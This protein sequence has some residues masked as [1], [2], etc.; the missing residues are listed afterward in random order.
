MS[1]DDEA[2]RSHRI[3]F[4]S[5]IDEM[6]DVNMLLAGRTN[7]YRRQRRNSQ[8]FVGA[9]FAMAV[10]AVVGSRSDWSFIPTWAVALPVGVVG[11]VLG[12]WL[13]GRFHDRY[14][15]RQYQRMVHEM[16]GGAER[17]PC[18]FE[19]RPDVLWTKSTHAEIAL[20]WSRLTRIA[21][22][23]GSIQFWFDPGLAVVRDRAFVTP[24]ERRRFLD[25]ARQLAGRPG[26]S[27]QGG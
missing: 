12:G 19:L 21:D 11:G 13:Y 5:T 18:V 23:P 24:D 27:D 25:K 3:A 2:E 6:V 20:P 7:A 4:D 15:R 26:I 10:V 17:V 9:C 8:W 16:V 22:V 14:I 1:D